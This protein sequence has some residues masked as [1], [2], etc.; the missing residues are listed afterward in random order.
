[1]RLHRRTG[2]AAA[3]VLPLLLSGCSEDKDKERDEA[4]ARTVAACPA[5]VDTG[6]P[7]E[8]LPADFP[9]LSGSRLYRFESVGK[10]R[11]WYATIEGDSEDVVSLRDRVVAGLK[12]K[13]YEIQDTDQEAGAEAEAEFKGSHD[14]TVRTRPLCKDHVEI[15]YKLES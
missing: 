6:S 5:D 11:V 2:I 7:A 4:Q 3:I 8:Q 14:G 13:G 9:G 1:M 10:T 12:D 15:R